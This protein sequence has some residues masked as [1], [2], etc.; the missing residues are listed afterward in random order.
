MSIST[1]EP[2]GV[3]STSSGLSPRALSERHAA[4]QRLKH[5]AL[6]ADERP[7][8]KRLRRLRDLQ[9]IPSEPEDPID[10]TPS[11]RPACKPSTANLGTAAEPPNAHHAEAKQKTGPDDEQDHKHASAANGPRKSVQQENVAKQKQRADAPR[12]LADP[13]ASKATMRRRRGTLEVLHLFKGKVSQ[14][15]GQRKHLR[16]A[17]AQE[18]TGAHIQDKAMSIAVQKQQK[19]HGLASKGR[20]AIRDDRAAPTGKHLYRQDAKR[21]KM[22]P[23][24]ELPAQYEDRYQVSTYRLGCTC[25]MKQLWKPFGS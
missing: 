9:H 18:S 20:A 24:E 16:P 12:H 25:H 6:N 21:L 10:P 1:S 2:T 7:S 8:L 15:L 3:P 19:P 17:I 5:G 13:L 14:A 4:R 11:M 23:P 22:D